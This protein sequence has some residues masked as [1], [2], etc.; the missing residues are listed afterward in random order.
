MESLGIE[1]DTPDVD[2]KSD[3]R[4]LS[5]QYHPERNN[6]KLK[7]TVEADVAAHYGMG[8]RGPVRGPQGQVFGKGPGYGPIRKDIEKL[9]V[10]E[11]TGYKGKRI[12]FNEDRDPNLGR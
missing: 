11:T 3:Y 10:E 12:L 6:G 2:I 1:P 7:L 8:E 4:K 5:M 9:G